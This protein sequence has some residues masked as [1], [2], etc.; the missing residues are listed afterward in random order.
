[1]IG[2]LHKLPGN[3]KPRQFGDSLTVMD[4]E[5]VKFYWSVLERGKENKYDENY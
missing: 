1:M 3:R 2:S 4:L 5:K